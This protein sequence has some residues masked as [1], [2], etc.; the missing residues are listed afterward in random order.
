MVKCPFLKMKK[1]NIEIKFA[2]RTAYLDT[3]QNCRQIKGIRI[4][5]VSLRVLFSF[6][7]LFFL[8]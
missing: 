6:I 2:E 1:L 4:C 7:Y 5:F 3:G 8:L